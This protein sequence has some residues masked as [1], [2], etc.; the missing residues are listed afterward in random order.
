MKNKKATHVGT[1]FSF[2]FFI[3]FISFLFLFLKYPSALEENKKFSLEILESSLIRQ[4][5]EELT[6]IYITNSSSQNSENC[7][8]IN[9]TLLNT[10]SMNFYCLDENSTTLN[11]RRESNLLYLE[12]GVN[13]SFFIIYYSEYNFTNN[14]F[15][16]N[17]NCQNAI[18]KTL[19]KEEKI[20]EKNLLNLFEEYNQNYS[21]TRDNLG[22]PAKYDF[23][24][25]FKYEN[26]TQ[27]GK[28]MI[29]TKSDIY[30]KEVFVDYMDEELKERK[31]VL[32]LYLW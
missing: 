1:I 11:S 26:G 7:I 5:S 17:A 31:G 6:K 8:S 12:W 10:N 18:I 22:I 2:I 25:Q 9:E 13:S 30:I 28:N 21:T 29:E 27:I 15:T 14:N 20:F 24:I 4:I 32:K 23:N 19:L 16:E 3:T